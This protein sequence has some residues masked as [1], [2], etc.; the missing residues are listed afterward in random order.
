LRSFFV[1]YLK[2]RPF[3]LDSARTSLDHMVNGDVTGF[4]H[5]VKVEGGWARGMHR[6][7]NPEG[8]P[9]GISGRL[10]LKPEGLGV[11]AQEAA[12][13]AIKGP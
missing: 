8:L 12:M 11:L 13:E 6:T 3:L 9:A 7:G 5:G 10:D 2:L 1:F 4:E